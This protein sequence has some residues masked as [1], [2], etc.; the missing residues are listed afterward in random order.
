MKINWGNVTWSVVGALGGMAILPKLLSKIFTI[1]ATLSNP[2]LWGIS[3][4][5]FAA[6]IGGVL[7][8]EAIRGGKN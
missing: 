1:P 3:L 6:A 5:G 7:I 4:I 8:V 2:L